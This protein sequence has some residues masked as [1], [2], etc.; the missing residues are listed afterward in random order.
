[1]PVTSTQRFKQS[2]YKIKFKK[3]NNFKK[4][5]FK[6]NSGRNNSGKITILSKGKK[7]QRK[8]SL[9]FTPVLWDK[10]LFVLRSVVY[11]NKRFVGVIKHIDGSISIAPYMY[12]SVIG[13]R[14]F[15]SNLPLNFWLNSLPGNFVLL[16]FLPIF[17]IF[18]NIFINSN[19]K[20]SLSNGTFSQILENFFDFNLIK[21]SLPSKNTRIL[22][23][24][25]FVIS[26]RNSNIF[27]K[28]VVVGKAGKNILKGFKPKVRGVAR[29]PVDHPHGGRT[30]TNSPEVS[31]WGWIAKRNK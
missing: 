19:R 4:I 31:I 12:G 3:K 26:G 23:G 15:A 5:F 24:W 11:N 8:N 10:R 20:Y 14:I 9:M 13:Q 28:C 25:T 16:K 29:N 17:S 21:F 6:N 22:S 27:D 2:I 7:L 30:K 1:M 18:S